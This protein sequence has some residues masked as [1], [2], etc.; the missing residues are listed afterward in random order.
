MKKDNNKETWS[1]LSRFII[2]NSVKQ[3]HINAL[4]VERKEM[5]NKQHICNEFNYLFTQIGPKLAGK[6]EKIG[7]A[8]CIFIHGR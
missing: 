7:L 4:E 6:L 3:K 5:S 1:I 2:R 8:K